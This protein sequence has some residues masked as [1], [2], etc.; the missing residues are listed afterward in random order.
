MNKEDFKSSIEGIFIEL[1]ESSKVRVIVANHFIK[2]YHFYTDI[3]DYL[4]TL[5][6]YLNYSGFTDLEFEYWDKDLFRNLDISK[7]NDIRSMGV[8]DITLYYKDSSNILD[9]N[10]II[11]KNESRFDDIK[12]VFNDIEGIL[13]ELKDMNII[14]QVNPRDEIKVKMVSLAKETIKIN[15]ALKDFNQSKDIIS[16]L[17]DYMGFKNFKLLPIRAVISGGDTQYFETFVDTMRFIDSSSSRIFPPEKIRLEFENMNKLVSESL[18]SQ[19]TVDQLKTLRRLT[20]G[21]DIG[22]RISDMNKQGANIDYINNP[23]DTGIESSED[24]EKKNK[25]FIPSWNLKH[26]LTPYQHNK[27]KKKK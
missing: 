24:Y 3:S 21:I 14:Y 13:I 2:I 23:I 25:N 22:D 7:V 18:P 11:N 1:V 8:S 12:V 16:T 15:I 27:N 10:K 17:I 4:L 19:K 20:K 9:D 6:D 5:Y 26:L